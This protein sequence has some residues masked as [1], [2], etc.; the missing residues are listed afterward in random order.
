V[1]DTAAP[2]QTTGLGT[3]DTIAS[4]IADE[5]SRQSERLLRIKGLHDRTQ[6]VKARYAEVLKEVQ[7]IH[8]AWAAEQGLAS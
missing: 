6:A 8:Q 7:D 2:G 5:V 3:I 1:S 4:S